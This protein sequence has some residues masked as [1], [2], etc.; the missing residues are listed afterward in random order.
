M[1]KK[2]T[3]D[4]YLKVPFY[5][6]TGEHCNYPGSFYEDD[7]EWRPNEPFEDTITINDIYRGRSAAHF[8][9]VS[10]I[11]GVRYSM[12]MTSVIDLIKVA[13]IS[14]G[15]IFGKFAFCKKGENYGLVI[16][17]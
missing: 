17:K 3:H 7:I 9:A 13:K 12:F 14:K 8:I 6:E 4:P 2:K 1:A 10:A 15:K 16:V 11:T 5:K